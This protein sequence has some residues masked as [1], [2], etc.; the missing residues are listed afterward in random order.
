MEFFP[1]AWKTK[2]IG[3]KFTK[4]QSRRFSLVYVP[5]ELGVSKNSLRR[6]SDA[7]IRLTTFGGALLYLKTYIQKVQSKQDHALLD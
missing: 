6:F 3:P 5:R 2:Y 7:L 1:M 4:F